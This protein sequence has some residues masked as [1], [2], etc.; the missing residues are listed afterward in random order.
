MEGFDIDS[1]VRKA[2]TEY[3]R[4]ER[5]LAEAKEAHSL[6]CIV[7]DL[8]SR[9]VLV[10]RRVEVLEREMTQRYTDLVNRLE[11]RHAER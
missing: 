1:I 4:Q 6:T 2:V 3:R 8:A 10:T 9:L 7:D 11:R 5:D